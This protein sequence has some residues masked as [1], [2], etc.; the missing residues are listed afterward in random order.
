[1][2]AEAP[3]DRGVNRGNLC[4][5]GRYG[6]ASPTTP[7]DSQR[8][9]IRRNGELKPASWDEAIAHVVDRL[10]TTAIDHGSDAIAGLA[11]AKC[12]NEENYLFQKLLRAGVA[13][14]N[15]DH[16]ARL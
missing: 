3:L 6:G 9:L 8:R 10:D 4:A 5:K 11:S 1:M 15:V 13:T 7:T 14:N 12:T 16:C 2:G